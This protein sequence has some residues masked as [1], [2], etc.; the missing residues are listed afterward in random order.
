MEDIRRTIRSVGN[1]ALGD[2]YNVDIVD[3]KFKKPRLECESVL[4]KYEADWGYGMSLGRAHRSVAPLCENI[5]Y[6]TPANEVLDC[7]SPMRDALACALSL[8]ATDP[9]QSSLARSY[10][11]RSLAAVAIMFL[12]LGST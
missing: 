7:P 6:F 8:Y 2:V 12:A 4:R 5:L 1:P 11:I 3:L 10:R 9:V